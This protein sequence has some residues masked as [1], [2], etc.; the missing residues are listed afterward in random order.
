[1]QPSPSLSHLSLVGKLEN[2]KERNLTS[3]IYSL[4]IYLTYSMSYLLLGVGITMLNKTK[5]L[6]D[7]EYLERILK[8]NLEIKNM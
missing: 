2:Q 7:Q 3:F 4:N 6:H 8:K 1:M 5:S